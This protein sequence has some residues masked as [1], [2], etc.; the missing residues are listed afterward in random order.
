[1]NGGNQAGVALTYSDDY[2]FLAA[3]KEIFGTVSY[4]ASAE[5]NVETQFGLYAANNNANYRKRYRD[6]G[7]ASY[8]WLRSASQYYGNRFVGVNSNGSVNIDGAD[9]SYGVLPFIPI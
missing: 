3:E 4:T 7:S 9:Y 2:I 8:W 5:A 1:M 6:T